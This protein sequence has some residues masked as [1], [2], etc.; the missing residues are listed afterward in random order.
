MY[1]PSARGKALG[2]VLVIIAAALAVP[3]EARKPPEPAPLQAP[4]L[5]QGDSQASA[6]DSATVEAGLRLDEPRWLTLTIS[7]ANEDPVRIQVMDGGLATYRSYLYDESF[8]IIPHVRDMPSGEVELQFVTVTGK[9]PSYRPAKLLDLKSGSMKNE[10]VFTTPNV[11][12]PLGV[13]V[14]LAPYVNQATGQSTSR[15][16][17]CRQPSTQNIRRI[18]AA[19]GQEFQGNGCCVSCTSGEYC[20]CTVQSSCGTCNEDC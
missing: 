19:F 14:E 1:L 17:P 6:G 5:R 20:G 11:A 9:R 15:S 2:F 7:F 16:G 3:A 10:I 12:Q 18:G 4:V 8:G 13:R